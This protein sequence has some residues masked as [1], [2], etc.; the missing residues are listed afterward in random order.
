MVGV[1]RRQ[2][3]AAPAAQQPAVRVPVVSRYQL[4]ALDVPD[5]IVVGSQQERSLDHL[6]GPDHSANDRLNLNV[7]RSYLIWLRLPSA[8]TQDRR[9]TLTVYR[10]YA[11]QGQAALQ[12]DSILTPQSATGSGNDKIWLLALGPADFA[13]TRQGGTNQLIF[14]VITGVRGGRSYSGLSAVPLT[15]VVW[16]A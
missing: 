16:G 13:T 14:N 10:R 11:R 5:G 2:V 4:P 7:A 15:A 9:S 12:T 6:G 8:T 1:R 3:M